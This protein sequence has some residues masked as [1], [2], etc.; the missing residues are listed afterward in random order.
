LG[1]NTVNRVRVSVAGGDGRALPITEP[2]DQD[3][4]RLESA[5]LR[6]ALD[7]DL[8]VLAICRAAACNCSTPYWGC[9]VCKAS[10]ERRREVYDSGIH[11]VSGLVF[12]QTGLFP[13]DPEETVVMDNA[14]EGVLERSF[15]KLISPYRGGVLPTIWQP[16]D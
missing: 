7:R 15:C 2:P 1:Q 6:D 11:A 13:D 9:A 5:L 14:G 12:H 8:P 3:R 10:T 16:T 4:D